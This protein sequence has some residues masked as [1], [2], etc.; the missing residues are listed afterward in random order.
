MGFLAVAKAVD[1]IN[2]V[3][4]EDYFD[5]GAVYVNLDNIDDSEIHKILYPFE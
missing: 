3:E 1:A 5:T 4:L 2:G